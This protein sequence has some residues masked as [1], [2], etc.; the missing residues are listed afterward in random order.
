MEQV[1]EDQ[2][3]AR[4]PFN[5][6]AL[7]LLEELKAE[8]VRHFPRTWLH[9]LGQYIYETYGDTWEGVMAII[10]ILQQIIFTH[11]RIGCQHSRIGIIQSNSR[12]RERRN[13]PRR[14]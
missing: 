10:R 13:G 1:P 7:E 9:S 12:A 2:G 3:P 6:W 14:S 5:E 11:Y 8:A 4:E